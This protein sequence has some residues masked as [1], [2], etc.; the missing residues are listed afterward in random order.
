MTGWPDAA[1]KAKSVVRALGVN[2][3]V[4]VHSIE[5]V[6]GMGDEFYRETGLSHCSP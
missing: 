1:S 4:H 6:G 2:W 5:T 3:A